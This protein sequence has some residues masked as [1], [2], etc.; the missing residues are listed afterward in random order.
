MPWH[1]FVS[2][3][4]NRC[5]IMVNTP[6][7]ITS[8]LRYQ[9]VDQVD[10]SPTEPLLGVLLSVL[11]LLSAAW[12]LCVCGHQLNETIKNRPQSHLFSYLRFLIILIAC[13]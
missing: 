8:H 3:I 12:V 1:I 2:Y 9:K 7:I 5:V 13:Q 11:L 6:Q 10:L 4:L